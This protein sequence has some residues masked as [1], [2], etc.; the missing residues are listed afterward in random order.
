MAGNDKILV[1]VD[2]PGGELDE[3]GRGL[4][5][6]GAR[7][8]GILDAVLGRSHRRCTRQRDQ[9]AGFGAY[10]TP[11]IT[12]MAGGE[13]LLDTPALL[14]KNLAQLAAEEQARSLSFP[15]TTSAQPWRRS[16]PWLL[17]PPSSPR[18]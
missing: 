7:L 4:L 8:A 16:S 1:F 14:G 10:G 11:A 9:L 13:A 17:M 3:T 15:T 18:W 5:S 6:Y 12:C 2:L